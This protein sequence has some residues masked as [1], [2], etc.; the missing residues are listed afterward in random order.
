MT[1]IAALT[2]LAFIALALPAAAQVAEPNDASA[3][4]TAAPAPPAVNAWSTAPCAWVKGCTDSFAL[5]VPTAVE[6]AEAH[7]TLKAV[8]TVPGDI[9]RIGDLVDNAGEVANV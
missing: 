8:V 4:W 7:P 2:G 1:R 9:V 3:P 6:K 5:L